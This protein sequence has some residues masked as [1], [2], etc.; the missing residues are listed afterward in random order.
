MITDRGSSSPEEQGICRRCGLCCD[1]TLFVQV[2]LSAD[3]CSRLKCIQGKNSAADEH[4]DLP[5]RFFGSQCEVYEA[6]PAVC[7][8]YRCQLLEDHSSGRLNSAEAFGIISNALGLKE[9]V[10]NMYRSHFGKSYEAGF[11]QLLIDVRH[12]KSRGDDCGTKDP[13]NLVFRAKC[14]IF[15]TLLIRYFISVARF[16]K[17]TMI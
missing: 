16:E 3:D 7:S 4:L 2:P 9:E 8:G 14:N 17:L 1:G 10:M 11:R 15:E 5:C 12:L 6:R 13:H